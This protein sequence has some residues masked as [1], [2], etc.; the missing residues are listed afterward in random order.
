[1][2][3]YIIWGLGA[4][5]MAAA[6]AMGMVWGVGAS[7]YAAAVMNENT[8]LP[9]QVRVMRDPLTQQCVSCAP[10]TV[11]KHNH[12]LQDVRVWPRVFNEKRVTDALCKEFWRPSAF[13]RECNLS[14]QYSFDTDSVF[15]A[16]TRAFVSDYLIG[17][18]WD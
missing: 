2:F 14:D 12:Q 10:T 3:A 17:Y 5:Q 9:S 8:L 13:K 18:D 4:A 15:D 7:V 16:K 6:F 11:S 1:M